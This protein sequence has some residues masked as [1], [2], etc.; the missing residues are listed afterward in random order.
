MQVLGYLISGYQACDPKKSLKELKY[1]ANKIEKQGFGA[2]ILKPDTLRMQAE[3]LVSLIKS[4]NLPNTAQTEKEITSLFRDSFEIASA[5]GLLTC[6]L[7]V[8]SS[9]EIDV[10]KL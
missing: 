2:Y 1:Y 4:K 7:K 3:C 10:D 5:R 6:A 9:S 8:I